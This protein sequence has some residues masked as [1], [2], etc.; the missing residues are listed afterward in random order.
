M[1]LT[2]TE[3]LRFAPEILRRL[4]EELG[5]N[6]EQGILEL[7]RNA[8]D[9]DA[10]NCKVELKATDEPGGTLRVEDDGNGMDLD[11]LRSGWLLLG[12]SLKVTQPA[13]TR[14][15]RQPIGEKGLGR[16]AALRLGNNVRL[17]SRPCT[18][19]GMEYRLD[20]DWRQ[21]DV[22]DTV[23]DVP[24]NI[25][26]HETMEPPGTSIEIRNL[27]WRIRQREI[28]RLARSLLL[29][30]DPFGFSSTGFHPI[31]VASEFKELESLVK[32]SYFEEANFHLVATLKEDAVTRQV[33]NK[34]HRMLWE[35]SDTLN[36]DTRNCRGITAEFQ[37][38]TFLLGRGQYANRS[39]SD[40]ELRAWLN[41]VG[42][43]HLYHKGL[44]VFPYGEQGHDWLEMNLARARNPEDRPSTNNSIGFVR[45]EDPQYRLTPKTDRTGFI[46][47]EDFLSI[48]SFAV[49]SLK[50]M[51]KERLRASEERRS[52][53]RT[54][55]QARSA[56]ARI[57]L[58]KATDRIA[59]PQKAEVEKAIQQWGQAMEEE[60]KT[61]HEEL[62]LY[63]TL[64]TVGTTMA[65]FAH[66]AS[67]PI[68][69][70][71]QMARSIAAR[72]Q[73][74]VGNARYKAKLE[75]PISVIMS[76]TQNLQH[77]SS[78]ILNLVRRNKRRVHPVALHQALL[79]SIQPFQPILK[80]AGI[81]WKLDLDPSEPV[82]WGSA[83]AMEAIVSNL[84]I[85]AV[86]AIMN[87]HVHTRTFCIQTE[88]GT[89]SVRLS[90]LDSGPGIKNISINDIWLPGKSTF[91]EGTGLGLT[92]VKDTVADLG[93]TILAV[94]QGRLGGAEFI[95]ELSVWQGK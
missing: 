3:H 73:D 45:I 91:P 69:L 42:G 12:R 57:D 18:Q 85:N 19:R 93:G 31:L 62:Q 54:E 9:A 44:R 53:K 59:T 79:E 34:Q 38:W 5:A 55:I 46:E 39:V 26:R 84:L 35:K 71:M 52:A 16:L 80:K 68:S 6:Q 58:D 41:I 50:W 25:M 23:E 28:K 33:F 27:N 95:I 89:D 49:E 2:T 70:I 60:R 82:I 17:I 47:N 86:S 78:L 37:F 77:Y 24:I 36:S 21:F 87:A 32:E 13:L 48:R 92:I 43:V 15:G 56:K 30:A 4:G 72:A 74:I 7:V 67:R 81:E 63:R 22:A 40:G 29:L 88:M 8:Y 83:A 94:P 20:I 75:K 90:F 51:A 64:A 76:S 65:V 11:T 61:T 10:L 66:E 1:A 14:L